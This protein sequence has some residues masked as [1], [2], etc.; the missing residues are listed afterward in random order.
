[1]RKLKLIVG[2]GHCGTKWLAGVL[3]AQPGV[4]FYHEL[5]PTITQTA[6]FRLAEYPPDAPVYHGYWGRI[7]RELDD[8]E[9]GDANSWVPWQIP[10][11]SKLIKVEIVYLV[12]NGIQQLHSLSTCSGVWRTHPLDSFAFDV[13]LREMW[14][15]IGEP[16]P[17]Y[18]EWD[19]WE[20]L[21]LL[22][23]AN[24]RMPAWLQ[25]Q[26]LDVTTVRL[27]DLVTDAEALHQ[28]APHL[29]EQQLREWQER[30]VNRKVRGD[31]TP[32][33]LWGQWTD[34]QRDAFRRIC[35]DEMASLDYEIPGD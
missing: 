21:C 25:A 14:R 20:R 29:D 26:G 7:W 19:R 15:A 12:R 3:N 1:M 31:R 2:S 5:R 33:T 32:A 9:V 8:G 4:R 24:G 23:K 27:E 34:M 6:W 30:D 10:A 22:V 18:D 16:D 17:P 28:L 35:G 11:V 13:W